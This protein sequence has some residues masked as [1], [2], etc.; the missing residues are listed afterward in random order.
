MIVATTLIFAMIKSAIMMTFSKLRFPNVLGFIWTSFNVY[1]GGKPTPT[2]IDTRKSYKSIVFV[3]L[4]GGVIIWIG[5]RSY[6]TAELSV[7]IKKY[8][9]NDLY[10]LSKT[11]YRY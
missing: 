11:N 4:L 8:P 3:S 10:S 5:Y 2:S 7:T 6:L 1:L 9:F